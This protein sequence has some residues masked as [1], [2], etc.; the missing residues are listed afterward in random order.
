[1]AARVTTLRLATR[2]R[3]AG[4]LSS[5][6]PNAPHTAAD[7]GRAGRVRARPRRR[8]RRLEAVL[9]LR[10]RRGPAGPDRQGPRQGHGRG[11]VP[12][13]R[14]GA[15]VRGLVEASRRGKTS[16]TVPAGLRPRRPQLARLRLEPLRRLRPARAAQRAEG[17]AHAVGRDPVLGLARARPLPALHRRLPQPGAVVHVEARPQPVRAVLAG[18]GHPLQGAG[19]VL[20]A[21]ER[22]EPRALPLSAVVARGEEHHRP[23]RQDAARAVDVGLPR[24][25]AGG[26]LGQGQGPVRRDG[27]HQL[28]HGHALRGAVPEPER[29][30]PTRRAAIEAAHGLQQAARSCP[31]AAWPCTRTTRT[32]WARC[33]PARSPRTR[34]PWPTPAAPPACC[35]GPSAT[36]GSR[37]G[38]ACTSP[39]SASSPSR[40]TRR[41]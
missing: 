24:P 25:D 28:A 1:M 37:A 15:G 2:G 13:R 21:L 9:D 14:R 36:G 33:S 10:G 34:C 31:S 39:S 12:G 27:G 20:L 40:R 17:H 5:S 30:G 41:A 16:R 22:A 38:A 3:A 7:R 23:G 35:G 26:P 18:R 11:Q 4:C 19:R 32:P 6:D 8:Q 29:T